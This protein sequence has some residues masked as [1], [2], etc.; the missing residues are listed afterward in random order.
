MLD[1]MRRYAYSWT[2]RIILILIVV[3]FVFWGVGTGFFSTVHPIAT[4]DGHQILADQVDR[5]SDRIRQTLESIYGANAARL[6]K[7]INVREEALDRLVEN[8]LINQEAERIG[9]RINNAELQEKIA[10]EPGFQ[11]DSHFDFRQYRAILRN[12]L[13]MLPNEYEALVRAQMTQDILRKMVSEATPV[14]DSE[15]RDVFDLRNE[16]FS[17]GYIEIPYQNFVAGISPTEKQI[18]QYYQAHREAFREPERIAVA[19]VHY[20]PMM[21]A[22]SFNPTDQEIERFYHDN[23]KSR[24]TH[25]EQAHASHILIRVSPTASAEEQAQAKKKATKILR[26]VGKGGDFAKLAG[27]YSQDPGSRA[28][29]GDLGFFSREQMIKPFADAVFAMKP[30][31]VKIVRTR[32]GYHVVKLDALRAAHVDTLAEAKPLIISTLRNDQ[33][34]RLAREALDQ[35]ISSALSGESLAGIARKRGLLVVETPFFSQ[36]EAAGIVPDP[37]LAQQ[38]LQLDKGQVRAVMD[39][40]APY[41]VKLVDRKASYVPAFKDIEARVRKALVRSIAEQEAR[42]RAQRLLGEIKKSSDFEKVARENK[43]PVETT[44]PFARSDGAVPGIGSFPEVSDGAATV[45]EVPGVIRRVMEHGGNA[46]VFEVLS[47]TLPSD[48]EW[49]S[50]RSAFMQEYAARRQTQAWMRFVNALKARATIKIDTNQLG[51]L[52]PSSTS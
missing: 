40:G 43:F 28:R 52:A 16:R 12:N 30:G 14:S 48:K 32:F 13:N 6:L 20:D 27:K 39:A 45:P 19:Y 8:Y 31:Q 41:L 29:G 2:T 44:G 15:A 35:D 10:S 50:H 49:A 42:T 26:K 18:E 11:V 23:L 36:S 9:I 7:S 25:P 3:V 21:L 17:L 22:A 1:L 34:T 5:E 24:F 51:A 46:Y 47:R 4:V 37:K 33:G 38:A